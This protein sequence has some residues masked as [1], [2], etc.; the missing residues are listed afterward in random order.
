MLTK[1]DLALIPKSFDTIGDIILFSEFPKTKKEKQLGEYVLKKFPHIKVIAKKTEA[2]SGKYRLKKVKIIAGE[3]RKI[4]LHKE[5]GILLKLDIEKCYFSPRLANE[6]MRIFNQIKKDETVLVMFSGISPYTILLAKKAKEVYGIE[7]NPI[8]HKYAQ[9][10]VKLNKVP[11]VTLFKVDVKKIIPKL[12]KK[13]DRII[14]P[15]PKTAESF[16]ELALTKLKE[17]GII[18]MYTFLKEEEMKEIP[19]RFPRFKVPNITRCGQSS[20]ST[21]RVC[22]DLKLK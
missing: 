2:H 8:A 22:I 13:F 14:M 17:K 20:P 6:R 3:K 7:A 18:H 15:L 21:F 12:N 19:Q 5:N 11:N 1:K 4:T 16:L 9:E 10:N